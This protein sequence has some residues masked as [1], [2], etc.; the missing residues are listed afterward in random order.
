MNPLEA[1]HGV[2]GAWRLLHFDRTGLSHF[3]ATPEGFWNSF[4]VALIALPAEA[5]MSLLVLS[6]LPE[7]APEANLGRVTLVFLFIFAVRWLAYLAM[8]AEFSE[9]ILRR[10]HFV[11]YTVAYNWSQV[12]RIAILLPAVAIFAMDGVEGSG[13]GIAIFYGAQVGLWV[14]SWVIARIALDAPRGAAV[15]TVVIEIA[16]AGVFALIFNALV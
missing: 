7:T 2:F 16:V 1:A 9:A 11:T 15:L 13:W 6:A 3:R 10:E 8:I 14:Y 4:W 5:I 12:I